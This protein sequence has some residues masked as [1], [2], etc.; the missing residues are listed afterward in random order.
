MWWLAHGETE[1]P[2]GDAWLSA[3]EQALLARIR[4][5]KRHVE[6]R[7]RRWTAKRTLALALGLGVT[8]A[9]FATIE[10]GHERGGAPFVRIDGR[11]R[12][13]LAVSLSDRAGWAVCLACDGDVRS[14]QGP[15]GIDLECVEPRSE[16]FVA[17]FFTAA[18]R[19]RTLAL[20]TG[21]ARDEAANLVWS[22]KEA[23]LK[24]MKTGL[25][26]DTRDV[27]VRY[28][29][30]LRFDGWHAFEACIRDGATLP[31]WWRREGRFVLTL[32]ATRPFAPPVLLPG[33][34]DLALA[35]PCESWLERPLVIR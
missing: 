1:V 25:R 29:T 26:A 19:D 10:I 22:A 9:S 5:T 16:A 17:D 11:R 3:G 18:E 34:S 15:V 12:D 6:F 13:E 23:A 20:P 4:F 2:V 30:A 35:A 21:D 31:G 14:L 27:E 24:V 8:P 7:T 33:S 32:A 28:A